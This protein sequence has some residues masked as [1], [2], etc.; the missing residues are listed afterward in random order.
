MFTAS[1]PNVGVGTIGLDV[2]VLTSSRT[3]APIGLK[4]LIN[5]TATITVKLLAK[6]Y[7]APIGLGQGWVSVKTTR[8][9]SIAYPN[10]TNRILKINIIGSYT[11]NTSDFSLLEGVTTISWLTMAN[12]PAGYKRNIGGEIN[13][14]MNYILNAQNILIYDFLELR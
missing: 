4:A 14:N 13:R 12:V 9:N 11:I 6:Y 8:A 10:N 2:K 3:V 5:E 1:P 7:N